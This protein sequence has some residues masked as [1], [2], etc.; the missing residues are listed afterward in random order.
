MGNSQT[1]PVGPV[2]VAV[3]PSVYGSALTLYNSGSVTLFIGEAP[4]LSVA[5]GFPLSPGSSIVWD[6]GKPVYGVSASGTGQI[7]VLNNAGNLNDVSALANAIIDAGL[8]SDIANQIS[9][10]GAPTNQGMKAGDLFQPDRYQSATYTAGGAGGTAIVI[11]TPG[12]GISIILSFLYIHRQ[13]T[14]TADLRDT[15]GQILLTLN[16]AS[17]V[18][19]I[20]D[21]KSLALEGNVGINIEFPTAGTIDLNLYYTFAPAY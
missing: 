2:A 15:S 3:F 7:T 9:L 21:F 18:D 17:G 16:G 10:K 12:T 8:A 20:I 5:N 1:V 6:E 4:G 14:I 13:T 11:G 19:T